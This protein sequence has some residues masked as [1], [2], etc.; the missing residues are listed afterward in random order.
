MSIAPGV[1]LIE[2]NKS[3]RGDNISLSGKLSM[4]QY[5][6]L[7]DPR[8]QQVD[9]TMKRRQESRQARASNNEDPYRAFR[10]HLINDQKSAKFMTR[11]KD[12]HRD[13]QTGDIDKHS[14]ISKRSRA[15]LESRANLV[16]VDFSLAGSESNKDINQFT[17]GGRSK[18]GGKSMAVLDKSRIHK[19]ENQWEMK[20]FMKGLQK[21][22]GQS[23]HSL[24]MIEIS[25]IDVKDPVSKY[26]ANTGKGDDM[27]NISLKMPPS[28][29]SVVN[30]ARQ[31]LKDMQQHSTLPRS[32]VS[33]TDGLNK[34]YLAAYPGEYGKVGGGLPPMRAD[35][36]RIQSSKSLQVS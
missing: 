15:G 4:D 30:A 23:E 8:Q 20:Q 24:M 7:H 34:K 29:N 33:F 11:Q 10:R 13:L 21:D 31:D 25:D 2:K 28:M 17:Y 19:S 18:G 14:S 26:R 5:R 35:Q 12:S 27:V 3:I 36:G 6:N 9:D 22:K 1:E 32:N 16:D